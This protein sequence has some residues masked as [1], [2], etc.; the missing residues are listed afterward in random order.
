LP[1]WHLAPLVSDLPALSDAPQLAPHAQQDTQAVAAI[2]RAVGGRWASWLLAG[3]ICS[4]TWTATCL[5][6]GTVQ[7]F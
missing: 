2:R 1:T 4:V 3:V 7:D 5:V 6:T